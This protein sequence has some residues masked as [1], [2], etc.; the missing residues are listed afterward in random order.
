MN[1]NRGLI[2][3]GIAA[4]TLA[5]AAPAGAGPKSAD[6][7]WEMADAIPESQLRAEPWVRPN[8]FQ[9][10]LLD[11]DVL[12]DVLG[13]APMEF[14]ER[15]WANPVMLELPMPDGTFQMFEVWES[16]IMH[17]DLAAQLPGVKTWAGQ[18]VDDPTATLRLDMTPQGF[19][20]QVLSAEWT[21]QIDPYSKGD[22]VFY[23]SYDRAG[24][25]DQVLDQWT[26]LGADRPHGQ[27]VLQGRDQNVLMRS[28]TFLQTYRTAVAAT[29]EYTV[30]HGGTQAAGQA[31]IVTA[32]NRVT[33]VYERELAIRL[34]LVAN[35][36]NI[37]Y[38][39]GAT[40]PYTNN[41]GSTMLGQNQTNINAV[42]GS[43]NYDIGHVFSTGGG[44]IAQLSVVCTAS[45]ARGVT[46]LPSPTGDIFYIDYVSHEMGHQFGALHSFN[47]NNAGCVPQ[48]SAASAYEPGSGSTI[49]SYAGICGSDNLQNSSNDYFL[50]RSFDEILA[51]S[52][53]GTGGC[54]ANVANGNTVP[55][56]DAGANY[57]IPRQTPFMLTGAGSDANGDTI[58]YCWEQRDLGA[59]QSASGGAFADLG[60]GPIIRSFLPNTSPTRIIP[61]VSNLL[62]N[63]FVIGE[64]L[65]NTNRT[66]NFRLTIR[67]NRAGGGGVNTDDMQVTCTTTSGPFQVTFPNAA[68]T[69]SGMIAV[70]W[71]VASTTAAPVSCA[72]V[73]IELSTDGGNNWPT[74]LNASTANDGSEAV[75]LP[76]INTT[77]A[78]IRVRAVGN[79]FFDI[80]N[81]NFTITP[82]AGVPGAFS[83]TSPANGATG[84]SLT[85]TLTWGT[86]SGATSYEVTVD[87]DASFTP[88]FTYQNNTAST[89]QIV[90]GATLSNSTVY[91]WRVVASNGSGS[92]NGS[93]NPASF[94]TAPPP[95]PGAFSLTTPANGAINQS[96]TPTLG[97]NASSGATSYEVTVDTD[98]GF[99]LPNIY[100]TSTAFTSAVVP[101]ATLAEGTLYFWRVIA[102]NVGGSTNGSPNP[103]S[104]TTV[105]PICQGDA[106]GDGDRDFA[107]ITSALANF[108][109]NYSPVLN[110]AGDANH[111]GLVDFSDVT[112]VLANFGSPC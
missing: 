41:N 57:T 33:G 23:A 6:G 62:A 108:G 59:A 43:A 61:R 46:G 21:V 95:P 74:V 7:M 67:D 84:V 12:N 65:P 42:I 16:P 40:D 92:T 35:N 110:G 30:F 24:L 5:C 2:G 8:F 89:S 98:A 63:T 85:P 94:T 107:D 55:T 10:A 91:F 76:P 101:P 83:L 49:M 47:S 97:W 60:S 56:A 28:G 54:P 109:N 31:A 102:S 25:R 86:A 93:P 87:T 22:T 32:I 81:A 4:L 9:G 45:K 18:G 71:N 17:P 3:L 26:C 44:G 39:D 70:T 112:A 36:I 51:F 64:A 99:A 34:T 96:V 29:G 50:H 73:M 15:A 27:P 77:T 37:V 20:A 1:R 78:R 82:P 103:A 14:T 111:D 88:P 75:T 19:H 100:Q 79:I 13:D 72:N 58:T 106:D 104:F 52:T 48:R 68:G 90:P 38:T 11:H 66:M 69:Q 80:S 53:G 105:P